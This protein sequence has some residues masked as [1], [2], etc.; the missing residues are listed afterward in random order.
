MGIDDILPAFIKLGLP[1]AGLSWMLFHWLY[2]AGGIDGDADRAT[3]EANLGEMKSGL[4]KRATRSGKFLRKRGASFLRNKWMC[5]GGGFY[6]AAALWT[7][8]VIEFTDFFSLVRDFPGFAALFEDGVIAFLLDM[9]TN[10]IGT[11]VD[12]LVWFDY[13]PD[14]SQSPLPW[15]IIAYLGYWLGMKLARRGLKNEAA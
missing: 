9:L 15:V 8:G 3:V 10:Q 1:M 14:A 12:A 5:F 13:W 7:L 11:F 2:S 6:G 4:K